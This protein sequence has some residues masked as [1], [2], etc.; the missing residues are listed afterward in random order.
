MDREHAEQVV[1]RLADVWVAAELRRD[2]EF[3]EQTLADDFVAVG[4]LGFMLTKQAW[5]GR[6]QSGDLKYTSLELDEVTVRVYDGAAVVIGRQVQDATYRGNSVMAQLR[7]TAVLVNQ[8]GCWQLAGVHMS[9][10]GQ[11]PSPAQP[12]PGPAVRP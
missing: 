7:T 11:P 3:L 12:S 4:P 2:T 10:I 6:H 1:A 9:A 8:G 5:I